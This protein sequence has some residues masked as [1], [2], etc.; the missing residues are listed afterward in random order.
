MQNL[1]NNY[2]KKIEDLINKDDFDNE[3]KRIQKETDNLFDENI[4]ALLIVDKYGRNNSYNFNISS[5]EVGIEAT[6][7]GKVVDVG[8]IRQFKKKNGGHGKVINLKIMDNTGGCNI[9]LWDQDVDFIKSNNVK[10]GTYLK[11]INGQVKNGNDGVE[12][13]I[14]RWSLI[15]LIKNNK[16]NNNTNIINEYISGRILEIMPSRAYFKSNGDYGF[17]TTVKIKEKNQIKKL[18]IWDEKVKEIQKF[19]TGDLVSFENIE[20]KNNNGKIEKHI[21]SNVIIK[22][23]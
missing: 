7:I 23:I 21:N 18:I 15:E 2:Y 8:E 13:N 3:I 14:G 22:K 5:L 12:I 20:N 11:I 16:F 19:K 9:V 6:I 1:K 17:C 10:N 4:S